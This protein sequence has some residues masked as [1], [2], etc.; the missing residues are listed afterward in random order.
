MGFT[1][2]DALHIAFAQ[3]AEVDVMLSTDDKLLK[4][5]QR[6]LETLQVNVVN[7]LSWLQEILI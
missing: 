3:F 1:T 4:R 7:P 5:A 6:H 2:C